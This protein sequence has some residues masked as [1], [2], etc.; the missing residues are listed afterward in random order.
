MTQE[1]NQMFKANNR[2]MQADKKNAYENYSLYSVNR[3]KVNK[4]KPLL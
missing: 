1:K 3:R 2:E 4:R